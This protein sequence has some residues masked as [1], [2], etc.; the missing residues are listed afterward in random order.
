MRKIL[1]GF[2][3]FSDFRVDESKEQGA[4]QKLFT[5]MSWDLP[6][7]ENVLLNGYF[8]GNNSRASLW[9]S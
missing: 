9:S 7:I 5:A 6:A 4:T 8:F 1:F 2:V 3:L